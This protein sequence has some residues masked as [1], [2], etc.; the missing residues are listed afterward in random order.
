MVRDNAA[1]MARLIDDI[2]AFSRSG[3]IE[4]R[5]VEVDMDRLVEEAWLELE[6]VRAGRSIEFE[7]RAL[8]P[9][10]GD[11]ALLRQVWINLLAN[12]IKFTR[13]RPVARIEVGGSSRGGEAYYV[14]DNGVGFEPAYAHKLFGVF[15]RLHGVDEFEGTGIG[16][17][18]VKRIVSRHGGQVFS[19]S[20]VGEG[21]TF[22]F[23]LGSQEA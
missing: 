12:A 19:E 13:P 1:R 6:P 3:R 15:Q 17:A 11:A 16:L 23:T 10:R 7:H 18:I 20:R 22:R 14:S 4:M 21:A 2:L 9:A 8:A 5:R